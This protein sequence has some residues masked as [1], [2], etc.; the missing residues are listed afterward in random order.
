MPRRACTQGREPIG[1]SVPKGPAPS[2]Y[3]EGDGAREAGGQTQ[4]GA[5]K[6]EEELGA[7]DDSDDDAEHK[8]RIKEPDDQIARWE[9]VGTLFAD[10]GLEHCLEAAKAEK[11]ELQKARRE[12]KPLE[13]RQKQHKGWM[14]RL[15]KKGEEL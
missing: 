12:G 14:Y 11:E 1:P 8:K 13:E 3:E 7:S 10:N 9:K 4:Q 15:K 5:K 2:Q 6:K